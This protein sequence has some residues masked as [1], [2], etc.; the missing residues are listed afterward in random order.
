MSLQLMSEYLLK[1]EIRRY[2]NSSELMRENK[3]L[4]HLCKKELAVIEKLKINKIDMRGD[5]E[6]FKQKIERQA[7]YFMNAEEFGKIIEK[8]RKYDC[9]SQ[10]INEDT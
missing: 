4:Y 3:L 9:I 6:E 2:E 10:I 1:Q 7:I 5:V 8:A